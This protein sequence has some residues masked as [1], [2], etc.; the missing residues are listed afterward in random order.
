MVFFIQDSDDVYGQFG[1]HPRENQS[2]QSQPEGRF[3][4]LS[5]LREGGAMGE[6]RLTLSALYIPARPLDPSRARDGVLNGTSVNSVLFSSGQSRAHLILPI[7]NDAFL[8][9]GAHFLIQVG[10]VCE[11]IE[12]NWG[13]WGLTWSLLGC[14][15]VFITDKSKKCLL[16]T[17]S[18][19]LVWFLKDHVTLKTGVMAAAN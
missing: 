15:P 5:F 1:F 11:K 18:A 16:S 10:Y 8:Q 17:K 7:R 4:S 14:K 12:V 2:I 3:L 19:L 9:N 6:V 13:F